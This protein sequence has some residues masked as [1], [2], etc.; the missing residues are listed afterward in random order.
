[1]GLSASN[2]SLTKISAANGIDLNAGKRAVSAK[3]GQRSP[4]GLD[5]RGESLLKQVLPAYAGDRLAIVDPHVEQN[6]CSTE[7]EV[8][9]VRRS[10]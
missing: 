6:M 10:R 9:S 5:K 3:R 7:E 2:R 8:T 4:E 1:M